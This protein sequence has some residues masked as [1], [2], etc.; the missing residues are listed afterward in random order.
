MNIYTGKISIF[1]IFRYVYGK[2]KVV[3][4]NFQAVMNPLQALLNMMVYRRWSGT[5]EHVYLPCL[6][7][8]DCIS[9]P[10]YSPIHPVNRVA[11]VQGEDTPL[12]RSHEERL[13]NDRMS[14]NGT[15]TDS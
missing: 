13:R 14:I 3:G 9:L 10:E 5:A 11:P 7:C 6:P 2:D 8:E 12:L 15:S 4:I 1:L